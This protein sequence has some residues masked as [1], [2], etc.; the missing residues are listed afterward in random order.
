MKILLH[1]NGDPRQWKRGAYGAQIPPEVTHQCPP[2]DGG[3]LMPC[4]GLSPFEV[5]R[6]DRTTLHP[7]L[8]T[9]RKE[10]ATGPQG[11]G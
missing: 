8:V 9:C 7:A 5:P 1:V 6:T 3:G 2:D 4:C 10:G 11:L